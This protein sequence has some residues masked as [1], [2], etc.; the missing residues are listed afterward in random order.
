[1][2]ALQRGM[3]HKG[4]IHKRNQSYDGVAAAHKIM[5]ASTTTIQA[6]RSG[7]CSW[8]TWMSLKGWPLARPMHDCTLEHVGVVMRKIIT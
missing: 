2:M 1:M 6:S 3:S 5:R 7:A 4:A 8:L